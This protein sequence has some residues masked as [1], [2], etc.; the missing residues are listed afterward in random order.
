MGKKVNPLAMR[1][2]Y[3]YAVWVATSPKLL[4]QYVV[5]DCEIRKIAKK[6]LS[7]LIYAP[8]GVER[9][10][11]QTNIKIYTYKP[12]ILIA[13]R[14][15]GSEALIDKFKKELKKKIFI[16][17]PFSV[18]IEDFKIKP[19]SSA[20]VIATS[21]AQNLADR[22]GGSYKA[23]TRRAISAFMR[24][25]PEGGIRIIWKGR[26]NGTDIARVEKFQDGKMPTS[27]IKENV[28]F[29]YA[30]SH[31]DVGTVTARVFTYIP[32]YELLREERRKMEGAENKE[33][34]IRSNQEN[35]KS[36]FKHNRKNVINN[37]H[38]EKSE[39]ILS[40]DEST[41]NESESEERNE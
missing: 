4:G 23:L 16:N 33:N 12:N 13:G 20:G 8:I 18:I 24:A 28:D 5:Q 32:A 38:Q 37:S 2:D 31:T 14:N 3:K 41:D 40:D 15:A 26:I 39:K 25:H 6:M 7:K 11:M 9:I 10:G 30:V 36:S 17:T 21:L 27:S 22:T 1:P 29:H 19:E 34:I 35:A